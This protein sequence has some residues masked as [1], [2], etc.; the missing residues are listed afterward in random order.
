MSMDSIIE[1]GEEN[2][3][4]IYSENFNPK[5]DTIR[6]EKD[7][8]YISYLSIVNG[9]AE[10]VGDIEIKND[11]LILNLRDIGEIS[12]TEQRCDRLIFKIKNLEDKKYKIKK[13]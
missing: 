10:Y 1:S 9:C 4:R 6:Y 2:Y 11:S 8:I 13:W 5:T 7:L 3:K 12:C